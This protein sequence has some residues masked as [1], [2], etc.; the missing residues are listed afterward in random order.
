MYI[1]RLIIFSG[2]LYVLS[3]SQGKPPTALLSQDQMVAI[4]VD[5][6]LAQAVTDHYADD[7]DTARW[8]FQKN[9]LLIYQAHETDLDTFQKSYQYYLTHLETMEKLYALV[10][11]QLEALSEQ[12]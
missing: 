11:K 2:L 5:L 10:I 4:L 1:H 12:L 7:E 3:S 8:L 6:E 9:A